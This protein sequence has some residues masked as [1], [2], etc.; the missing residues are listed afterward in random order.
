MQS[1]PVAKAGR[2]TTGPLVEDGISKEERARFLREQR[3]QRKANRKKGRPDMQKANRNKNINRPV[4]DGDVPAVPRD[5]ILLPPTAPTGTKQEKATEHDTIPPETSPS[6]ELTQTVDKEPTPS[7]NGQGR[8][9][10]ESSSS[11]V[12]IDAPSSGN[13]V[14]TRPAVAAPPPRMFNPTTAAPPTGVPPPRA[15]TTVSQTQRHPTMAFSVNETVERALKEA[16][17]DASLA[18]R[19]AMFW[20]RRFRDLAVLAVSFAILSFSSDRSFNDC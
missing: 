13:D 8:P 1:I 14:I 2:Q 5:A 12:K 10:E 16:K 9:P 4:T 11:T 20:L 18:D 15:V 3:E 7:E 6:E 19:R 17:R